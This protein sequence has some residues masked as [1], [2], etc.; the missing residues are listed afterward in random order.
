MV[1]DTDRHPEWSLFHQSYTHIERAL[2]YVP[3][4]FSP[5]LQGVVV[6][7]IA[8]VMQLS[9]PIDRRPFPPI[10]PEKNQIVTK[11]TSST[12]PFKIVD[13]YLVQI[14]C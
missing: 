7:S 13:A 12:I 9:K 11:V 14:G 1:V 8:V 2:H 6:V 3:L 4:P 5:I 10:A